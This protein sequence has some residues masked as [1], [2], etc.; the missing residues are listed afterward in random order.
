MA[1]CQ[2]QQLKWC[3]FNSDDPGKSRIVIGLPGDEWLRGCPN[4]QVAARIEWHALDRTD[5][6][7]NQQQTKAAG[8]DD[9]LVKLVESDAPT[10]VFMRIVPTAPQRKGFLK[11]LATFRPLGDCEA[12]CANPHRPGPAADHKFGIVSTPICISAHSSVCVA[13]Y[14][15]YVLSV[16]ARETS[17]DFVKLAQLPLDAR[18][19]DTLAITQDTR[20]RIMLCLRQAFGSQ[21][22]LEVL[23]C[24]NTLGQLLSAIVPR[25]VPA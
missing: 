10:Q 19:G 4:T 11:R 14:Q 23:A 13:A 22:P 5:G 25:P 6:L 7:W 15:A 21:L 2:P 18:L 1:A 20:V 8:F 17:L 3:R 12:L 24:P 9:H 16:V